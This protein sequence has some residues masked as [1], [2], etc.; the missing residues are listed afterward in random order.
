MTD[1]HVIT[2]DNRAHYGDLLDAHHRERHDVFVGERGWEALRREDCRDI[3]AYD[4][5]HAIY[6]LAVDG[7]KLVG[8]QRLYPTMRPHLLGEV[9]PHLVHRAIPT[10]PQIYEWTRYFVVKERR[11][12]RT[13][14]R[15]LAA[16][17]QFCL[18]EGI[19]QLS[20]VVEM[21]WLPR[22]QQAG[23]KAKP[24][25]LPQI[26]EGQPTVAVTIEVSL[27]SLAAVRRQGGIRRDDLVAHHLP[28]SATDVGSDAA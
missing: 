27:A 8:G 24:L 4:D 20:A 22:W 7:S 25:G 6:L 28:Q 14:C 2:R 5:E 12:G 3:D 17:Q 23:F 11:Y 18:N 15:L 10:G 9:F 19:T 1:V 26:V 21:W 16:I 13:D